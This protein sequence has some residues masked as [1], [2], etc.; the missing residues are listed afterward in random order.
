MTREARIREAGTIGVGVA[1]IRV[2]RSAVT[3]ETR[4]REAGTIR[5]AVA[6]IVV[7]ARA[8]PREARVGEAGTIFIAVALA[9]RL[10]ETEE[11]IHARDHLLLLDRL[12]AG[13]TVDR[14]EYERQQNNFKHY[15]PLG[16]VKAF[17]AGSC[18]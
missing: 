7:A 2:L 1:L 12:R 14:Q 17:W 5:V 16:A 9:I 18:T 13:E 15:F 3:G 4:I 11:R 10:L 6:L 8:F